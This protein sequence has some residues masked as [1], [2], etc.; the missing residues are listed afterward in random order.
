[1]TV[2]MPCLEIPYHLNDELQVA[3]V[4]TTEELVEIHSLMDLEQSSSSHGAFDQ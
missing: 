4:R 2:L 3:Q 1:M